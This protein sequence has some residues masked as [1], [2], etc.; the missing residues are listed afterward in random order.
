MALPNNNIAMPPQSMAGITEKYR[1]HFAWYTNDEKELAAI[2]APQ[3]GTPQA[4]GGVIATLARWT[5]RWWSGERNSDQAGA[6]R[7]HVN[8]AQEICR[9]SANVLLSE[10]VT[11]TSDD[12]KAQERLK[13]ICGDQFNAMLISAAESAAA[14]GGTFLRA[15][16]NSKLRQHTYISK[17]DADLAIPT[18]EA[19]I[20]TSVVF[21]R[22]VANEGNTVYRHVESHD[23]DEDGI[24]I[25]THALY[26]GLANNLGR[27]VPL[28]KIPE[29]RDLS[30][31]VDEADAISTLTPGLAVAYVPNVQPS[32]LWSKHAIGAYLGRS[33]LEGVEQQLDAL[34]ELHSSWMHDIRLG[35]GRL[36]IPEAF[37]TNMGEGRGMGFDVLRTAYLK[38]RSIPGKAANEGAA[39][40]EAIQ[41]EIRT[42]DHIAAI[43][44]FKRQIIASAGYSAATFG[45]TEGGTALTATEIMA[46]ERTTYMTRDRKIAA[47]SPALVY[48]ITKA[49]SMDAEFFGS[50]V[51]EF[52]VTVKFA[53]AVQPDP[54]SVSKRN[55]M[56]AAS[57]SSSIRTRVLN[58]HPDWS[59]EDVDREVEAIRE[60]MKLAAGAAIPAGAPVD[61]EDDSEDEAELQ[62][63]G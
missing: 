19:G 5:R 48:I 36:V 17:V 29:T 38:T 1:E 3:G 4:S 25:I 18:F 42:E 32:A 26:E 14:L 51:A 13:L 49:L 44:Y 30:L 33:D 46:R 50:G 20:L 8:L 57:N 52:G 31:V 35:K 47:M 28:S 24:G 34:D 63:A 58:A 11:I 37:L 61:S 9:T 21:I 62:L 60:E 27:N 56:D 23:V 41:F 53:D 16:W 55:S 7:I 6:S 59:K 2:Y 39:G 40:V 22:V 54:E 43:E 10:T 12:T 15:S 45:L